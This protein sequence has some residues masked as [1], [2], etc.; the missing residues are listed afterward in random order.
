MRRNNR[1]ILC[2]LCV[3]MCIIGVCASKNQPADQVLTVRQMQEDFD[4]AVDILKQVHPYTL[5][6]FDEA[7][8]SELSS[9]RQQIGKPMPT[10]RFYM[11]MNSLLG[12]MKDAHTSLHHMNAA[13]AQILSPVFIWLNDG[14]YVTSSTKPFQ[15]GDQVLSIGGKSVEAI[16]TELDQMIPSENPYW[17]RRKG[18]HCLRLPE[19]LEALGLL[20]ADSVDFQIRR[21]QQVFDVS[22]SLI[23]VNNLKKKSPKPWV[24]CKFYS[25]HSLGVFVLDSC[26]YNDQYKKAVKAFFKRVRDKDIQHV[27]IDVRSNGGGNSSVVDEFLSYIDVDEYQTYGC[28]IR[29]SKAS[30]QQRGGPSEGYK[31]YPNST[32]KKNSKK[33]KS[34]LFKGKLYILTSAS[35]F[36][37]GNWFA[38][39]IQ[40][41]LLGVVVGE[42]TGNSPSSYGDCLSFHMPNSGFGFSCSY[43]KW[44]RPDTARDSE[45]A[46]YPDVPVYTT[47][48]DVVKQRDPQLEKIREL[49]MINSD[50]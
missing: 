27:V 11:L 35:T 14:L 5:N 13:N 36:S 25:E 4:Y 32:P 7:Q 1:D 21:Q 22:A 34:V 3:F 28:E 47:I 49:T 41:N 39:V 2:Y 26:Q 15:P 43:K 16:F 9:L 45:D 19:Y 48:E 18:Q 20:N 46:L 31:K 6:G 24:R 44:I 37:S 38:V 50:D 30:A 12:M 33:R 29:H 17:T 42:P 10:A 8:Q 40:D 23:S